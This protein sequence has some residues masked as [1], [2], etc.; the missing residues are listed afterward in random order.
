MTMAKGERGAGVPLKPPEWVWEL[1]SGQYKPG[2]EW[3]CLLQG[4]ED[5]HRD[6]AKFGAGKG[7]SP[8][9]K[10]WGVT[11]PSVAMSLR[12]WDEAKNGDVIHRDPS[13]YWQMVI[14]A[15]AAVVCRMRSNRY[16]AEA[17]AAVQFEQDD[18]RKLVRRAM[19]YYKKCDITL[20]PEF[21]VNNL[22]KLDQPSEAVLGYY[23]ENF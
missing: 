23:K 17:D 10:N 4:Y 12:R 19:R 5:W 3:D 11:L 15:G 1:L 2:K 6:G 18:A 22:P 8:D 21:Y 16:M 13:S 20:A 14:K 9:Y 7:Q